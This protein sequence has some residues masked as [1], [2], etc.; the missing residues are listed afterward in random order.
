MGER[1]SQSGGARVEA[2]E[3]SSPPRCGARVTR[4]VRKAATH[5][6]A[7]SAAEPE[8]RGRPGR[9]AEGANAADAELLTAPGLS[10]GHC[11]APGRLQF[12]L[13][14]GWVQLC[15][16]REGQLEGAELG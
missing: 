13:R 9:D 12:S 8:L 7:S 14:R 10:E 4:Q 1:R 11:S 5:T 3:A 6:H 16:V 2:S 15:P